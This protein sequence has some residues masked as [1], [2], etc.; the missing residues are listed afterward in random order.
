MATSLIFTMSGLFY[1]IKI[2]QRI[3]STKTLLVLFQNC[4]L[5]IAKFLRSNF[6]KQRGGG[7]ESTV[8][9]SNFLDSMTVKFKPSREHMFSLI[10][11]PSKKESAIP[12]QLMLSRER[13][14]HGCHLSFHILD[15][16]LLM[17]M[18]P[19][20]KKPS[21]AHTSPAILPCSLLM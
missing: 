10:F 18:D 13:C 14:L 7:K 2:K 4:Y 16:I 8:T 12:T 1:H 5:W 15:M 6:T 9:S 3:H 21:T 11:A 20:N 19:S 17:R